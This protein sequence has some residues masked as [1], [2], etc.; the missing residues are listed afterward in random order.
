[1]AITPATHILFNAP[2]PFRISCGI[3]IT[4]DTTLIVFRL[5]ST[6]DVPTRS[7]SCSRAFQNV[8]QKR[9]WRQGRGTTASL[10]AME[11]HFQCTKA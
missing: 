1:M 9:S 3:V 11:S 7:H 2:Y 6:F 10:T 8:D 5:C 4:F